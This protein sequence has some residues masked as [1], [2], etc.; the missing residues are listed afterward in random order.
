MTKNVGC[1]RALNSLGLRGELYR[2]FLIIRLRHKEW[3]ILDRWPFEGH[4]FYKRSE[5][6]KVIDYRVDTSNRK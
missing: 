4:K 5:A 1:R 2:G 6:R 3:R